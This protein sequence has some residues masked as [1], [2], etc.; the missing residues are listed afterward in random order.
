MKKIFKTLSASVL[1]AL[2]LTACPKE[3]FGG[4]E[5]EGIYTFEVSAD[6]IATK[7]AIDRDGNGT[8]VNRFIMEVYLQKTKQHQKKHISFLMMKNICIT[9]ITMIMHCRKKMQ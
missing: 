8:A 1:M 7:A 3:E 6:N 2:A 9:I 4:N 5:A